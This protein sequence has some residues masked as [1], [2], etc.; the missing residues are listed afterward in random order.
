MFSVS[1]KHNETL[2]KQIA[3]LCEK[4]SEHPIGKAIIASLEQF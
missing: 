4:E 3:Y 1:S 2:C